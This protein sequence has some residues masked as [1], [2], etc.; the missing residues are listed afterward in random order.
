MAVPGAEWV[1]LT[2]YLSEDELSAV[3]ERAGPGVVVEATVVTYYLAR[4]AGETAVV[5]FDAHPV[6]TLQ[7]VIMVVVRPDGRVRR[8]VVLKFSEPPEYRPPDG[9]LEQFGGGRL[10]DAL[11]LKG[12]IVTMTG[13][14]LTSEAVTEAVRRIL[15]YHDFLQPFGEE[16]GVRVP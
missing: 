6:R 1:R 4:L 15:A 11:S 7:E 8:V 14:T 5:Y 10:D 16:S 13:A 2:A 3:A 9:W 12:D